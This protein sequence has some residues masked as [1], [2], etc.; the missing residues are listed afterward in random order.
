MSRPR[1]EIANIHD[2][3][4]TV[5]KIPSFAPVAD[6]AGVALALTSLLGEIGYVKGRKRGPNKQPG[7]KRQASLPLDGKTAPLAVEGV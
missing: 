6:L 4:Q 1:K 2:L 5:G 3:I 7:K